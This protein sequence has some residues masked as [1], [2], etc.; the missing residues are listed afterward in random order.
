[1]A[2]TISL[3]ICSSE[4][5]FIADKDGGVGWLPPMSSQAQKNYEEYFSSVDA[6]AMGSRSYKKV[7]SFGMDWPYDGKTSYVFSKQE[8][9]KSQRD[10]VIITK[11]TPED[12]VNRWVWL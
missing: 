7:L 1:M 12:F 9:L 11:E 4:D 2:L 5:G 8:D 6:L 3:Y 10:D